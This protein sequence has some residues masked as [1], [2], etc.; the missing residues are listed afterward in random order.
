MGHRFCDILVAID[1]FMNFFP[2]VQLCRIRQSIREQLWRGSQIKPIA[3]SLYSVLLKQGFGDA[4]TTG[5]LMCNELIELLQPL[6]IKST[7][8]LFME[9]FYRSLVHI[10]SPSPFF[11]FFLFHYIVYR[12]IFTPQRRSPQAELR[13]VDRNAIQ[14]FRKFQVGFYY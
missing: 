6:P 5:L 11:L 12:N 13:V 8:S 10:F 9:V 1:T 7:C 2:R 4:M 3:Q 14:T